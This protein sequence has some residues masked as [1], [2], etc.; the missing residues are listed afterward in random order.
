MVC[1]A[2]YPI[3]THFGV[4]IDVPTL[5]ALLVCLIPTTIGA[6][7]AAIEIAGMARLGQKNVLATSGRAVEAAGDIDVLLLDKTGAITL[8]NRQA[9]EFIRAPDVPIE[10]L[11]DAAQ[12]SSL[13]DETPEGRRIVVLA[14]N[15]YGLRGRD[16]EP[17][18]ACFVPFSALSRM[19]NARDASPSA[20]S[21]R[22]RGHDDRRRLA[23]GPRPDARNSN[24]VARSLFR[25]PRGQFHRGLS[26]P[27]PQ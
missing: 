6:L 9:S 26:L 8:G 14:K 10:E 18:H 4:R 3:G 13:A 23:R 7:L 5:V 2:L 24:P 25:L 19:R 15:E 12:L 21:C 27:R 22:L 17:L 16:I 11:V 20:D 1:A